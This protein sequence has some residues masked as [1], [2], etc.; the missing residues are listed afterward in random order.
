MAVERCLQS[1][2]LKKHIASN[3]QQHN[4]RHLN[5]D[6]VGTGLTRTLL[7][8]GA[9]TISTMALTAGSAFATTAANFNAPMFGTTATLTEARMP[10]YA[11]VSCSDAKCTNG[12]IPSAQGGFTQYSSPAVAS[13]G[14]FATSPGFI[15]K[16]N[17]SWSNV[18]QEDSVNY[19][20][21][22]INFTQFAPNTDLTALVTSNAAELKLPLTAQE[23]T[24]STSTWSGSA[25][26]DGDNWNV[27]YVAQGD[28]IVRAVCQQ[29]GTEKGS[30][31]CP[32]PNVRTLALQ[33][34]N[35]PPATS[36]AEATSIAGLIPQTPSQLKPVLLN[37]EPAQALWTSNAPG[38]QLNRA[39]AIRKNSVALQYGIQGSPQ[40]T[41]RTKV[42][43]IATETPARPFVKTICGKA[44]ASTDTCKLSKL[45][46]ES[47]GF[48]GASSKQ[49]TPNEV[50]RMSL[51]FTG[52]NKLGDAS[53]GTLTPR[54]GGLTK[55]EQAICKAAFVSFANAVVK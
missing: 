26:I 48:I 7:T 11:Q 33:V 13:G 34:V 46:G 25:V 17:K 14:V 38:A 3:K 15:A 39:M 45:P 19:S 55:N 24:G 4:R 43:A 10:T 18:T 44:V 53:C 41:L 54:E 32:M 37:I 42:A 23:K 20:A 16:L 52:S 9:L 49:A 31:T 1:D 27:V 36:L 5:E 22:T 28:A 12:V 51:H 50:A 47:Y 2:N 30:V 40:L 29:F 35:T 6:T 21:M 8:T